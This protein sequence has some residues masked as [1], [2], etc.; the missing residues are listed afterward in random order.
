LRSGMGISDDRD[1]ARHVRMFM[2]NDV[3]LFDK[4]V[5]STVK[6]FNKKT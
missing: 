1:R 6:F 5:K 3:D 2:M 4:W